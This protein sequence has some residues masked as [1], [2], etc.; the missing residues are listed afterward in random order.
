MFLHEQAMRQKEPAARDGEKSWLAQ[1]ADWVTRSKRT[2]A[3][4]VEEF[5]LSVEKTLSDGIASRR[6]I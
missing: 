6:G 5:T 1:V 2:W 3:M 4:L